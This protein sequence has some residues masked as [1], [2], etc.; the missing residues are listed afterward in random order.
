M[1]DRR[2]ANEWQAYYVGGSSESYTENLAVT[3]VRAVTLGCNIRGTYTD[4]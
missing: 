2:I 4:N 1:A 3:K